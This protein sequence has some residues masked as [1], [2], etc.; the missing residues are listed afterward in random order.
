MVCTYHYK[1]N[2]KII[3]FFIKKF[4]EKKIKNLIAY[5]NIFILTVDEK[6]LNK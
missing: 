6:L 4:E 1:K 3:I 2:L 5:K